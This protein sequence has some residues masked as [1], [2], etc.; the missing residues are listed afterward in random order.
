MRETQRKA[1]A[2]LAG[3]QL[4]ATVALAQ[5]PEVHRLFPA[6]PVGYVNDFA[7]AIDPVSKDSMED[8]R[9]RLGAATGA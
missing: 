8:L 4:A 3:L 5:A 9:A 2:L 6:Q 7:S 1:I